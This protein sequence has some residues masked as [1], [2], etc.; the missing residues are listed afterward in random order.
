MKVA[1][2]SLE[3]VGER[4]ARRV[5]AAGGVVER[6]EGKDCFSGSL[7]LIEDPSR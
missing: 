4:R 7:G 5:K 1:R 3:P 6:Y 2:K